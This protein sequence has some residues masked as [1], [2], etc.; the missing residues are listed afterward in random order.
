MGSVSPTV[1]RL[2]KNAWGPYYVTD[3]CNGCGLCATYSPECLESSPDGSY[4]YVIQQPMDEAEEF[5]LQ[6]A[7][8]AC[9]LHCLR[10]DGD[11][12]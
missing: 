3:E 5:A 2:R 12:D 1:Q 10:A 8:E 9:P 6:E 4:F 11:C 7:Q